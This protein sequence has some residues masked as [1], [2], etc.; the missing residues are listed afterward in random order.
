MKFVEGGYITVRAGEI[1]NLLIA[2]QEGL[3][4]AA[5]R[6]YLA[7]WLAADQQRFTHDPITLDKLT[8]LTGLAHRTAQDAMSALKAAELMTLTEGRLTFNPGVIPAAKPYLP[9]L[10]TSPERP[11][12]IPKAILKR[13][14]REGKGSYLI[15]ALV[16][17][18]RCL[19]IDQGDIHNEGFVSNEL[20]TRLTGLCEQVIQ[21]ARK[22]M[23]KIGLLIRKSVNQTLLNR[24]GGCYEVNLNLNSEVK[25]GAIISTVEPSRSVDFNPPPPSSPIYIN[26]KNQC[27]TRNKVSNQLLSGVFSKLDRILPKRKEN[28]PHSPSLKDIQAIDLQDMSRLDELYRQAVEQKWLPDCESS[29]QNFVGAAT[30]AMQVTGNAVKIFVGIVKRGLWGYITLAQEDASREALKRYL[31]GNP[32]GFGGKLY[33]P[34]PPRPPAVKAVR[35]ERVVFRA[36]KPVNPPMK[37]VKSSGMTRLGDLVGEVMGRLCPKCA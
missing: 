30:R 2:Y 11:V 29:I 7:G 15:G 10:K 5:I 16:H 27:P 20:I 1:L 12:P 9:D 18:L 21:T 32:Q 34:P 13:L 3:S 36:G 26:N 23:I 4:P 33:V 19:F 8:E 31:A 14:T 6:V 24:F 25:S 28:L 22:W 37:P 35:P 17:L